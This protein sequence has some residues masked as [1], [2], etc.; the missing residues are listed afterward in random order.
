[1]EN[2]LIK[3]VFPDNTSFFLP[4]N[5]PAR[6]T[7]FSCDKRYYKYE[8]LD[9]VRKATRAFQVWNGEDWVDA[10]LAPTLTKVRRRYEFT[11]EFDVV[12]DPNDE[13]NEDA[14][15]EIEGVDI[16]FIDAV[17][18]RAKEMNVTVL[19]GVNLAR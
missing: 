2:K 17:E 9:E 13:E 16:S 15:L 6:F 5:A 4:P 12:G 3:V 19:D 14:R 10:R 11:V 7:S 1:M 18:T 8:T